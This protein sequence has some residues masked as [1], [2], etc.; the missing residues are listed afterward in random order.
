MSTT[1]FR[2]LRQLVHIGSVCRVVFTFF[3]CPA[4]QRSLRL[5]SRSFVGKS[6]QCTCG[7]RAEVRP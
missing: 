6:A 4:C 5:R 7:Y 1:P 2:R 3:R